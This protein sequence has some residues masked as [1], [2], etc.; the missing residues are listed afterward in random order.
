M[1]DA[2]ALDA[3]SSDD[4]DADLQAMLEDENSDVDDDDDFKGLP[5]LLEPS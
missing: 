3:M 4:E 1:I 2:D 5:F